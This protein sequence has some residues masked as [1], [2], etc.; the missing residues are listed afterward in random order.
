M[1]I[2]FLF[3]ASIF[4]ATNIL[5]AQIKKPSPK[6]IISNFENILIKTALPYEMVN[7]TLAYISYEGNN[8]KLYKV[9]ITK[10]GY[11]YVVFANLSQIFPD[12]INETKYQY[13]LEKNNDFDLV[14]IGLSRESKM[15]YTR[16][17][18]FLENLNAKIFKKII[19]QVANVIDEIAADLK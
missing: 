16:A 13:L 14:K 18:V 1:K 7:D 4:F 9:N 6:K 17:D 11:L 5:F 15:F 12:K 8:L 2:F 10:M 19:A 3:L